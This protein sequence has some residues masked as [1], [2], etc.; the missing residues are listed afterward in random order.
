M[1]NFTGGQLH[2]HMQFSENSSRKLGRYQDIPKNG[3]CVLPGKYACGKP[4]G[5]AKTNCSFDQEKTTQDRFSGT[6]FDEEDISPVVCTSTPI[7]IGKK[8]L[9][10]FSP[11]NFTE[12][13]KPLFL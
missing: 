10:I 12:Q 4:E 3:N 6:D 11:G 2:S 9:N 13:I 5:N 1:V 7:G 8:N